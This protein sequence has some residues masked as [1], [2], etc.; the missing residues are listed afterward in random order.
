MGAEWAAAYDVCTTQKEH[1]REPTP[2]SDGHVQ[3]ARTT[4]CRSVLDG[5][6]VVGSLIFKRVKVDFISALVVD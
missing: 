3:T 2:G 4:L 1:E 6:H 5:F